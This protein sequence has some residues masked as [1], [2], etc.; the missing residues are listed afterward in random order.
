MS[1]WIEDLKKRVPDPYDRTARLYPMLILLFPILLSFWA[2]VPEKM[3]DWEAMAGLAFWC[4]AAFL[5]REL[6]RGPGKRKEKQL[7]ESWGAPPTTLYL[8]HRG[9]TNRTTLERVHR[10]LQMITP[11][12]EMPTPDLEKSQPNKADEIYEEC[13]RVMRNKTR[14]HKEFPL[15]F[16][17]LCSYGFWRNAW[18]LRTWG[19]LVSSLCI[20]T[21][22]IVIFLQLRAN[23]ALQNYNS[24][25]C[26]VINAVIFVFWLTLNESRMKTPAF[27]Y[28][29][30]LFEATEQL[31]HGKNDE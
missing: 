4:G 19:L 7:W 18:G 17:E 6:G 1:N 27:A 16:K 31:A 22:A 28:A 23:H 10:N 21:V 11:D 30:R 14:N 3:Y 25:I 9:S 5:L 20:L 8:R 26:E 13:T 12:I 29:E 24:V 2:V 15:V